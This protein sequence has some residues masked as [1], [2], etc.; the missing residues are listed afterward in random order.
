MIDR[1]IESIVVGTDG[2]DEGAAAVR[3]AA[4]RAAA[5]RSLLEVVTCTGGHQVQ[6]VDMDALRT[7]A[8]RIASE[9]A[10]QARAAHPTL[11][12]TVRVDDCPPE[13]TLV[14]TSRDA[15]MVVVGNR[16]RGAFEGMLLG[17]VSH[18]VIHGAACSVAVVAPDS[19]Q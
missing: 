14:A 8:E 3:F 16:G 4:E 17:S 9:A 6:N 12:V 19:P 5:C 11:T 7:S 18:A 2:S 15:G 10:E 1:V 13:E